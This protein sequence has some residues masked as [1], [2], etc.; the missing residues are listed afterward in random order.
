MNDFEHIRRVFALQSTMQTIGAELGAMGRGQAEITAPLSK[1]F[2]QH[3]GY[4]HA[5][6]TF[7]L[8]DTSAGCAAITLLEPGLGVVTSE[9]STHLLAP[10]IG[11]RLIARGRVIKPGKRMIV[12]TSDVFALRDGV[13]THIATLTGTMVPVPL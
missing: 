7:A 3:N 9:I 5:A 12:A 1:A 8:G 13:E 4:G 10:A 2:L 11:D 6:L